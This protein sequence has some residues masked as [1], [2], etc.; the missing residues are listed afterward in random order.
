MRTHGKIGAF[1]SH[2]LPMYPRLTELVL[3]GL[4]AAGAQAQHGIG[5][6]ALVACGTLQSG[7]GAM[8][9]IERN[10]MICANGRD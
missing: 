5:F 2:G 4:V 7:G 9:T 6:P 1:A 10:D 3:P 8:V